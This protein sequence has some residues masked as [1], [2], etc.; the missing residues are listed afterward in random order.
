MAQF[1][2]VS[3]INSQTSREFIQW[4]S[5]EIA[6]AV[7][8]E[9]RR[10]GYAFLISLKINRTAASSSLPSRDQL[11]RSATHQPLGAPPRKA[12]YRPAVNFFSVRC[13]IGTKFRS[14]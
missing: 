11:G 4:N 1:D 12:A 13:S 2:R 7:M 3:A 14:A 5:P 9:M 6:K 8:S 10:S